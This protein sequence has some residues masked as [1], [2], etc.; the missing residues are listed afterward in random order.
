MP[1]AQVTKRKKK[2]KPDTAGET[3]N[4]WTRN[5]KLITFLICLALFLTFFGPVTVFQIVDCAQ[6]N[7]AARNAMTVEEV[8]T[9]ADQRG[10]LSITQFADYEGDEQ[11]WSFGTYYIINVGEHFRITVGSELSTGA[12][13]YFTVSKKS[14][15]EVMDVM[16]SGFRI[17]ELQ[18]FMSTP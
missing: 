15:G 14:T 8:L 12:V 2:E 16:E 5:V 1:P 13:T 7:R 9:F 3:E 17:S 11:N 6:E 10:R 18:A 4:F